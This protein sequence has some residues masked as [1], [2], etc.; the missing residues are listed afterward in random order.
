MP[1][2]W[3]PEKVN[4]GIRPRTFGQAGNKANTGQACPRLAKE[5]EGALLGL[6]YSSGRRGQVKPTRPGQQRPKTS[7]ETSR[8]LERPSKAAQR[9]ASRV[10]TARNHQVKGSTGE[11]GAIQKHSCAR[12]N[13]TQKGHRP[14]R[15]TKSHTEGF[16]ALSV[17]GKD[18]TDPLLGWQQ[19]RVAALICS[20]VSIYSL[21]GNCV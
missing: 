16:L 7:S 3:K 2:A 18:G 15:A 11:P 14:G 13:A 9:I 19:A 21:K 20:F 5:P 8:V 12:A 10:L 4:V 6:I 1:R 17:E